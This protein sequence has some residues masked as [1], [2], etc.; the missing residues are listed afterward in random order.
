MGYVLGPKFLYKGSFL[1]GSEGVESK[2]TKNFVTYC[3]GK[4]IRVT[5]VGNG[6]GGASSDRKVCSKDSS[7]LFDGC[8]F[9]N[10]LLLRCTDL[11]CQCH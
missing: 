7:C 11:I 1:G 6:K 9:M 3:L 4:V 5:K 2:V 10:S 8:G